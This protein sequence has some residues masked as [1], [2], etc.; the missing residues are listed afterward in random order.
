MTR[1]VLTKR[2]PPSRMSPSVSSAHPILS[3][4]PRPS[5]PAVVILAQGLDL[6][7]GL[8]GGGKD[9]E[10]C[11]ERRWSRDCRRKGAGRTT[12]ASDRLL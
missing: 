4:L 9:G 5:T 1:E 12:E 6:R 10:G 2:V 7:R 3:L 11:P 8:A